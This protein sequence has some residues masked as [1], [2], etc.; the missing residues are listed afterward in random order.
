MAS[1]VDRGGIPLVCWSNPAYIKR[2]N[3]K[4]TSDPTLKMRDEILECALPDI[5]FSGWTEELL[6]QAVRDAGYEERYA[7]AVFPA[8]VADMVDHFADWADRKMLASLSEIDPET[9]RV[10]DRIAR[11]VMARIEVLAPHKEAAR[12]AMAYWGLPLRTQGGARALWRTADRIWMWAGDTATDYNRYTKRTLLSG[13]ISAT[14]LA[15]F[16]DKER[17]DDALALF[18]ERRIENILK[19]G[20]FFGKIEG[21]K[22]KEVS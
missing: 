10:R 17:D 12:L 14:F 20:R 22:T 15:W 16:D 18:L 11:A 1:L 9:L 6:F 21:W 8:G 19:I 4:K 13:V 2:M 7:W 5:V 3:E